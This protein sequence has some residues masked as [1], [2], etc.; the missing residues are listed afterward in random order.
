M[1]QIFAMLTVSVLHM[2]FTIIRGAVRA[3]EMR[4]AKLVS[5]SQERKQILHCGNMLKQGKS[6]EWP[7]AMELDSETESHFPIYDVIT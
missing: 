3:F 5:F 4:W 2:L 6:A 1:E 7:F